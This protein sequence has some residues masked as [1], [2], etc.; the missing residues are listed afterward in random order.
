[1]QV[2]GKEQLP[3]VAR[4]GAEKLTP[5]IRITAGR[6]AAYAAIRKHLLIGE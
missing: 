4:S 5:F 6:V 2:F 3:V 1:M